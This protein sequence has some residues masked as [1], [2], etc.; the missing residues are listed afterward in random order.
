MWN[1]STATIAGLLIGAAGLIIS[2]V[3]ALISLS[4]RNA[5]LELELKLTNAQAERCEKCE[6]RF[7]LR[8][9]L[10]QP[11]PQGNHG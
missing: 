3:T 7:V 4:T 10:A 11:A 9:E 6:Q 2:V 5:V 8:R 1:E